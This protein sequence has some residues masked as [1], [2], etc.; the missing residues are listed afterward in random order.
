[1]QESF[2]LNVTAQHQLCHR[3]LVCVKYQGILGLGQCKHFFRSINWTDKPS[4]MLRMTP[5]QLLY[6]TY[7][8]KIDGITTC[9]L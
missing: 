7:K 8:R 6:E 3:L 9:N 4:F 5:E 2:L 1:M